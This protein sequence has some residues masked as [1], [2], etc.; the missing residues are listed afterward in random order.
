MQAELHSNVILVTEENDL[1]FVL[2]ISHYPKVN[3]FVYHC[4]NYHETESETRQ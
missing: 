1:I 3:Y 4:R 2:R